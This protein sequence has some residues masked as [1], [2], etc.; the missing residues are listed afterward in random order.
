VELAEAVAAELWD[1]AL[2]VLA[3]AGEVDSAV[4]LKSIKMIIL[5]TCYHLI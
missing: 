5:Q 3:A 2:L 4:A 1:S